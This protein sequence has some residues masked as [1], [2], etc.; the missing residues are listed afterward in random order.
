MKLNKSTNDAI[1]ILI[2]CAR[3][4]GTLVK[5][6]DLSARLDITMQNVFKI[7][8]I[9]SR[10]DLVAAVRGRYGG[11]TLKRPAT[12]IRI[13][14]IVRAMEVVGDEAISGVPRAK[15]RTA[16]NVMTTVIDSALE[17]FIS[18]LDQH[19]LAEMAKASAPR[20]PARP[21]RK[22]ASRPA[23]SP[24][25]ATVTMPPARSRS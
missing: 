16:T 20:T 9:L 21:R 22:Q 1:Q 8:H 2:E 13:G 12:D 17:A 14:E 3:A 19:S 7:V 23:S 18:V 24:R 10:A 15:G 25:D 4:E 5:V 11:V 6:A